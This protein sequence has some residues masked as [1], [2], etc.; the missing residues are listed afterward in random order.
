[1]PFEDTQLNVLANTD[2]YLR[3]LY[4]NYMELPKELPP[5]NYRLLDLNKPYQ[6]FIDERGQRS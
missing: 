5:Q 2:L 1:V 6:Q 3:Q 4:G